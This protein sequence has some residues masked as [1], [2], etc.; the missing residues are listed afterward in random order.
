MVFVY[1]QSNRNTI[2]L[3]KKK[4]SRADVNVSREEN[5]VSVKNKIKKKEHNIISCYVFRREKKLDLRIFS[6]KFRK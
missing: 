1:R 6:R 4:E 2:I 3:K 5:Y